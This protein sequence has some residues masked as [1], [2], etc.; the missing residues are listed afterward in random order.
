[1]KIKINMQKTA[2]TGFKPMCFFI[3]KLIGEMFYPNL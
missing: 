3:C 2:W 1:M